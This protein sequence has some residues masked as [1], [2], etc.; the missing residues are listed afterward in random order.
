MIKILD[1]YLHNTIIGQLEQD[2]HGQ[3]SFTY[4]ENWLVNP[5]ATKISCSLPLRQE[6]YSKKDC[7]AFFGG[8]LPEE[9]QRKIIAKNLG[10][11]ANNDFSMLEKIGGECAGALTFIEHGATYLPEQASYENL[12]EKELISVLHALPRRPLLAGEK[13]IRL[14]LAGV[15]DKLA[16]YVTRLWHFMLPAPADL[17]L[18]PTDP[19]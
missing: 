6:S 7:Q 9:S 3:M 14:S 15:Q 19:A 16:V 1:V 8:I 10:I 2:K 5:N 18:F 12:S 11:S 4:A 17:A 13:N